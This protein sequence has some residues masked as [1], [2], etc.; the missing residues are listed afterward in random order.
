MPTS[1]LNILAILVNNMAVKSASH[2]AERI[3]ELSKTCP[4]RARNNYQQHVSAMSADEKA[5]FDSLIA[6]AAMGE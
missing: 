1:E 5:E 3:V 2:T 4:D 6:Q